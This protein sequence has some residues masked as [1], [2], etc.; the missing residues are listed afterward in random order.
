MDR[1]RPSACRRTISSDDAKG[2]RAISSRRFMLPENSLTRLVPCPSQIPRN[3]SVPRCAACARI[4]RHAI[5]HRVEFHVLKRGELIQHGPASTRCRRFPAAFYCVHRSFPL[6]NILPR[7]RH[8]E[9]CEH[10]DGRGLDRLRSD[11]GTQISP[12]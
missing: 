9:R 6:S 2:P 7:G 12:L 4:S 5:K 1:V 11:R 10:F 3:S 8:K